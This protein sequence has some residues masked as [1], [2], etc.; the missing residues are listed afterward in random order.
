MASAI[1]SVPCVS[2]PLRASMSAPTLSNHLTPTLTLL[3]SDL[4]RRHLARHDMPTAPDPRRGRACDA[5]HANK[6]KCDGGTKC[7]LC[8]KRGISCTYKHASKAGSSRSSRSPVEDPK[9]TASRPVP[10]VH[11]I[12][13]PSSI[14]PPIALGTSQISPADEIKAAFKRISNDVRTGKIP[15]GEPTTVPAPDHPWIEANSREYFGRLHEAWPVLHA[16][17]YTIGMEDSFVIA[18]SVAMISCWLRSPDEY[19]EVVMELHETIMN[20][21][22]QWIVS[23]HN[24]LMRNEILTSTSQIRYVDMKPKS[25]GR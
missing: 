8:I 19:G 18:T 14:T 21:L 24:S 5:C 15:V 6:T 16:P 9:R 3:S 10:D 2:A 4:L 23:L 17:S 20:T 11:E 25:L 22:S 12:N 13:T 1:S 7:T